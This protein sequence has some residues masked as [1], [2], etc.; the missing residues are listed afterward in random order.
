MLFESSLQLPGLTSVAL[1]AP[2]L[3]LR[4][5]SAPG[6]CSKGTALGIKVHCG[7]DGLQPVHGGVCG[8]VLPG[9]RPWTPGNQELC[10]EDDFPDLDSSGMLKKDLRFI[11][12]LLCILS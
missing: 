2:H 7:E 8:G 12:G 5:A 9:H 11:W 3:S 10:C 1:D 4:S 6:T